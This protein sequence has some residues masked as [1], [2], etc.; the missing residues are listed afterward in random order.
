MARL[1]QKHTEHRPCPP[2]KDCAPRFCSRYSIF[3]GN[4]TTRDARADGWA[5][6]SPTAK[7]FLLARLRRFFS[8]YFA[9]GHGKNGNSFLSSICTVILEAA[10]H[11][12][13]LRRGMRQER[14]L[15]YSQSSQLTKNCHDDSCVSYLLAEIALLHH[16]F[17]HRHIRELSGETHFPVN[18]SL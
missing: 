6:S 7:H 10:V 4:S 15:H 17:L 9:L 5:A 12:S 16:F 3:A 1:E 13:L 11:T 18:A 8:R 14:F 2:V